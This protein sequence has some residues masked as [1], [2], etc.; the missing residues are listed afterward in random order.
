MHDRISHK[1]ALLV[2]FQPDSL[3]PELAP[4][5]QLVDGLEVIS[6]LDDGVIY[7]QSR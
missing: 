3:L 4:Y 5:D 1:Q 6:N 7:G 2:L